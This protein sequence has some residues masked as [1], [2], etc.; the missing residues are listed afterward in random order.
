MAV[1]LTVIL[2]AGAAVDVVNPQLNQ[3]RNG[4]FRPPTTAD[5]LHTHRDWEDEYM[6]FPAVA[7]VIEE[8]RSRTS[9]KR[10]SVDIEN[11]LKEL[12]E[13][14]KQH[15]NNT[16]REFPL[17]LQHFFTAVSEQYC[18]KPSNYMT[19][20]GKVFDLD[21]DGVIFLTTNYDLLFDQALH[22][23]PATE[24]FF[25]I[26]DPNM[27]K[28]ITS[29]MWA[30]IKLHG[31]IDWG[32]QIKEDMVKNRSSTLPGLV[33]NIRQLG[34]HLETA[35]ENNIIR[36]PSFN[37]NDR[38]LIYPTVS[39]PVGES[40]FNCREEHIDLLKKHLN[41]CQHFL[42]IGFSGYDKDVL[43]LL[44]EK[45]GGYGQVLFVSG[46]EDSANK[47]REQFGT[48]GGLGQKLQMHASIYKGNGFDEFVRNSN[49]LTKYLSKLR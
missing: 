29:K 48:F 23:H 30:Y 18:R 5:L 22:H 34:E 2:G 16:F 39:V 8:L 44:D 38:K 14:P 12:K 47:A 9:N 10:T 32:R 36:D 19:L 7:S 35:L 43:K 46:S 3:V 21:L 49:G 1:K 28:Y 17:Y 13:S 33:D 6:N 20:I 4:I 40:K 41:N 11:L 24:E 26:S 15:R 45:E 27:N 25:S 31:S 42:V 37:A